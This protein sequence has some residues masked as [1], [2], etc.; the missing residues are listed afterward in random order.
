MRF[1]IMS[2]VI[3]SRVELTLIGE[4]QLDKWKTYLGSRRHLIC[5][6]IVNVL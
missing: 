4:D 3:R 2:V 1:R 5:S 6:K